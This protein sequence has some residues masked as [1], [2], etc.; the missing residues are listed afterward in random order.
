MAV[1]GAASDFLASASHTGEQATHA[2]SFPSLHS[3][4]S[5]SSSPGFVSVL[6]VGL[7]DVAH[8]RRGP[9][10]RSH[11]YSHSHSHPRPVSPRTSLR[12]MAQ[13]LPVALPP[14]HKRR[15]PASIDLGRSYAENEEEGL[16]QSLVYSQPHHHHPQQSMHRH[17][18]AHHRS[19]SGTSQF[20]SGSAGGGNVYVHPMRLSPRSY[21]RPVGALGLDDNEDDKRDA[22]SEFGDD[23]GGGGGSD[24]DVYSDSPPSAS[25]RTSP[26][27]HPSAL[28]LPPPAASPPRPPIHRR[29]SSMVTSEDPLP[30]RTSF[31]YAYLPRGRTSTDISLHQAAVEAARQAFED[32]EADKQRKIERKNMRAFEREQRRRVYRAEHP[33]ARLQPRRKPP[34]VPP[35]P[36]PAGL[37]GQPT[38]T[39]PQRP[40]LSSPRV[41]QQQLQSQY[42]PPLSPPLPL[43]PSA[44][45]SSPVREKTT[46]RP[47]TPRRRNSTL[48]S[49]K[50]WW[51]LFM[52]WLRTRLFKLGRKLRR[53]A[54]GS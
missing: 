34:G 6:G 33:S 10:A 46:S 7:D 37:A 15:S 45:R 47:D 14:L 27:N 23:D 38:T 53:H 25:Y 5:G 11:S 54:A 32:R 1:H 2:S 19:A 31:D 29:S 41:S 35:R 12:N 52:T 24:P 44:Y 8:R 40:A 39:T 36:G 43:S 18:P 51:V 48:E 50:N 28:S 42:Q 20:S 16:A 17:A 3:N 4:N 30:S 21:E 26:D 9:L 22:C 13:K 49:P